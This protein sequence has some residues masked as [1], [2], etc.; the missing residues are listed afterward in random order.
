M[1]R[2]TPLSFQERHI[3]ALVARFQ[4]QRDNYARLTDPRELA[5]LRKL[6]AA[7]LL[8]A[9][10][11][12]GKTLIATEV[13]A[14]FSELERVVWFWFAPYA[15]LIDQ[16][17]ASLRRQAPQLKILDIQYQRT[18]D[19]LAPGALFVITWQTVATKTKESRLARVTGDDG[20]S[21]D[22]LIALARDLGLRIGA[23]V[24]E[25][26][27]GFVKAREA[28]RFFTEVL[29]PDYALLMTATPKDSDI[30]RFAEATGYQV[31][32]ATNWASVTRYEGY[33]AG[34]LKLGVK[35]A[36]FLTRNDDEAALVDFEEVALS[37]CAAMHRHLKAVL[38][39][40]GIGLTPLMLV[41]VPNGGAALQKA[42][43]YLTGPLK[44]APSA[45]K[46]HVADEPDPNLQA[47]AQDPSVEVL[48]F[49]MAIAMGF[50][51]PRAFTLAA[52]RGTRDANFGIQ[53]VGRIMRV[54]SRLQRRTDLP[55]ILNHGYVFLANSEAQ[56]G[57]T[58]AA[59]AINR[60]QARTADTAP[61]TVVTY[62]QDS[63]FVQVVK[64]GQTA[65]IFPPSPEPT[66][67]DAETDT[68]SGA[69]SDDTRPL[70]AAPPELHTPDFFPD[71]AELART[72]PTPDTQPGPTA[73]VRAFTLDAQAQYDYPLR[74]KDLPPLMT[75]VMPPNPDGFEEQLV[76][77]IDFSR[78]LIDRERRRTQLVQ[79]TLDIFADT[80]TP[81]DEDIWAGMSVV[82]IAQR[83]RQ[84]AFEYGDVDSRQFLQALRRR[85]RDALET[86]GFDLPE[87]DEELTQQLELVLVRNPNLIRQAH[88]R[89]RASQIQLQP[90]TLPAVHQSDYPL[91]PAKRNLY[92]IFP[93]DLSPDELRFTEILDT[94]PEVVWWH[95]NPVRKPE[96]VALYQ[97]SSGL[98]F[99][100]DFL[101]AVQGRKTGDGVALV[102]FK[103]PH[104]Q[105]YDKEKAGAVHPH[106]GRVFMVGAGNRDRRELR[107]F[108]LV[109][110]ELEDDGLFEV[111]RLR[112]D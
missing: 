15:T 73:L 23:V 26:H 94:S 105:Q 43:D 95:R 49:K 84:I 51:A 112:H 16:A 56:E 35:T 21:V 19:E 3:A 62:I 20:L 22:D 90:V 102:E 1:S 11:G 103:G 34:L 18:P 6:S 33:Q 66:P 81:D 69:T 70:N 36:R 46:V 61:E 37:Q 80:P 100:P 52:L 85:F 9:P 42:R 27:H 8:Q 7:V 2:L 89:C 17:A 10:T 13:A 101:V 97:W 79:R 77:F 59:A 63:S 96:S 107:L 93:A 55:P 54:H 98:G 45:V 4:A 92:G 24:D 109:G 40:Q 14:R 5:K 64:T 87:S 38:D 67:D 91:E 60:I 25:A 57:L 75:E 30:A 47:L 99:F 32:D 65:S 72:T 88:K 76:S 83:A 108:R 31:G 53:V 68:E 29:Q 106:Y 50:D 41:Q 71:L 44:F 74:I 82:G 12:I 58:G 39:E 111:M 104:L 28:Y 48:V 78:V 86:G 110:G